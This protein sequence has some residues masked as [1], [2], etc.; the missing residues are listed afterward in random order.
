MIYDG[1]LAKLLGIDLA[2]MEKAL[3]KQLG[4]EGQGG[5]AQRGRAQGRLRLRRGE[6][7]RSRIRSRIEPMNETAGKILI[8]GNA[9]AAIGCMMAGVTVVAW[10][11]I[12]PSSSLCES[13]IGYM[14]KYRDRQGD[15]EGDVR[16][17]AG[18][19]R[20]R[21][22]RHGDRRE[23]G[24]RAVDDRDVGPGHLADGRVR[25]ARRTTPRRRRSSSTSS[26]SGRRRAC[27]PA[28]RR[29]TCCQTAFLSHGDTK[30][31]MLIPCSVEEC[32]TMAHGGVRPRRAVPD[33]GVRDDGPRPRHEQLD[34][35]RVH[36][37]D[38]ADQSRQGA[39]PRPSSR[40]S[41]SGAAT[42]TWTATASRTARFRATACRRTSR[43]APATTR[44]RSTASGPT[45]TSTTWTGSRAS[46]RRR[47][48]SCRSRSSS[49]IRRR[50]DRLHRLRHVALGDRA[51]AATSCARRRGVETSYFR[52][53]AYPFTDELAAFIDAHERVYVIEQNRD[54]QMLQLMKLELTPERQREA[55]QRAALQRPADRR[56][57]HHRRRAGAG[58]LRGARRRR[59]SPA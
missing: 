14:K 18:R 42:R 29:A 30:H 44:R 55:A 17:R 33:A 10:Y 45:T 58:R 2:L 31:I 3:G 49:A 37:S 28:R 13:L 56:P 41:A 32:Y 26:A 16:D 47:A 38:R 54:A 4:Q 53:R 48:R 15:R 43:A 19:G 25:R 20:D 22:A 6:P 35:G 50:E 52:L 11:P 24:G 1:V 46:S 21:V 8:E 27:R 5:R 23:L 39:R 36:V 12:T 51:R 7:S 9:A 59:H 40:S 57:Q 34:V